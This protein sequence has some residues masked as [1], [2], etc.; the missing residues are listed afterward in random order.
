[1]PKH[2]VCKADTKIMILL[3]AAATVIII[4]TIILLV[5]FVWMSDFVSH[6]CRMFKN[7]ML[8]R[9]FG[10]TRKEGTEAAS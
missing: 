10:H 9:I 1:M 2:Y 7:K 4:R 8:R 6:L 5:G 3:T